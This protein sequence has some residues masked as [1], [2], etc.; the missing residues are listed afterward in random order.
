MGI[1]IEAAPSC[2]EGMSSARLVHVL[3]CMQGLHFSPSLVWAREACMHTDNIYR[4]K[5]VWG[6]A[7]RPQ[8]GHWDSR[9]GYTEQ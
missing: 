1:C 5:H 8:W 3:F 9:A 7:T 2:E 4:K 6:V